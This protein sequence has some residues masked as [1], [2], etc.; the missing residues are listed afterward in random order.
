MTAAGAARKPVSAVLIVSNEEDR[1]ARCLGSLAWCDE[2]V[3]VDSGSS[4][5]TKAIATDPAAPWAPKL[6]W[7]ERAWDG[8]RNQRNHALDRA[9]HDWVLAAD[10]DEECTPELR[11]RIEGILAE[12]SPHPYWKVRRQEYF[13]GKPIR[14]GIWN[15]SYQ[16]RFFRK[17][18]V[19]YVNEIHEYAKFPAEPKRIHEPFL[20]DPTFHPEKFLAKM[21]RYTTIEARDRVAA[22][23]R[24]NW[25]RIVFAGPAMFLKNYFYYK[26][27]Q[28]G[29]HGVVISV[30]EGVSRAVRHVKIWQF[31]TEVERE[32]RA[33][34]EASKAGGRR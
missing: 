19:R 8:F 18:G 1:I 12:P 7:Y 23:M 29:I 4:D 30:L 32:R 2:I 20:H 5:R 28:D 11:S 34:A 6:R 26:A 13:L 25:F 21:N 31:Q 10:A 14:R 16:D 17:E 3:V 15:P 27:W 24:T 22:G 33:I 9:T